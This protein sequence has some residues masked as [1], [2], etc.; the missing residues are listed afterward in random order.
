MK[1]QTTKRKQ[2]TAKQRLIQGLKAIACLATT[3]FIMIYGL[4][5]STNLITQLNPLNPGIIYLATALC[6]GL[7][8]LLVVFLLLYAGKSMTQA[9][10]GMT[11]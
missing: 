11:N 2:L 1:A 7:V 4:I 5:L 10:S 9:F 8:A 3:F 6:Y